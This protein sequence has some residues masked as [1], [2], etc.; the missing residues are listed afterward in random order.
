MDFSKEIMDRQGYGV[1]EPLDPELLPKL[2]VA[3][4]ENL[5][6]P[7]EVFHNNIRERFRRGDKEVVE[8]M[9]YW[10]ELALKVRSCLLNRQM[11]KISDLMNANFD[12]RRKIYR[13]SQENIQM[14]EAAR[15]VGASAKF[16]GSGGAIVGTYEN[17]QMFDHLREKLRELKIKVIKP[18]IVINSRKAEA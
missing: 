9:Q 8:A 15:S 6:E 2:Y 14:V 13:I 18:K 16:T 3:Y 17:E 11:E 4:H 5:S 7:T 12:Q 1:Y 10:A